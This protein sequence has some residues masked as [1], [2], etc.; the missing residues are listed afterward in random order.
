MLKIG[1]T[2]GI[3]S[4]KSAVAQCFATLGIDIIDTDVIAR[5]VVK[6]G[7]DALMAISTHFGPQILNADNTL[8]RARLRELIFADTAARHWLEAL[9]HPLILQTVKERVAAAK[10]SYS[11]IVVPLLIEAKLN[12]EVDRILVVDCNE[13]LQMMRVM[14]RDRM[15]DHAKVAEMLHAQCTRE[16]RL[17]FADDIIENSADLESLMAKVV[18][19]D[20]KYK[21]LAN[22]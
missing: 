13:S 5:E 10:S 4:G 17:Q 11:I 15:T 12:T 14:T 7:T 3:G 16:Q 19:I 6:P 20:A 9:L 18:T 21:Q 1:L 8:N 22:R 2:G